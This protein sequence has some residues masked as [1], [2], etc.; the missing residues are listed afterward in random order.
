MGSIP[1]LD[2]VYIVLGRVGGSG[3]KRSSSQ[4]GGE[5]EVVKKYEWVEGSGG[6]GNKGRWRRRWVEREIWLFRTE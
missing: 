1:L 2:Y 5:M 6:N 3:R 4:G